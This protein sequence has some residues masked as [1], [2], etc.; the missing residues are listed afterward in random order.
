MCAQ[1]DVAHIRIHSSDTPTMLLSGPR[2]EVVLFAETSALSMRTDRFSCEE[3]AQEWF[4]YYRG[5]GVKL[6]LRDMLLVVVFS[7]HEE[8]PR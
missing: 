8:M 7:F 2:G 6:C 3:T 5:S 1:S 4:S